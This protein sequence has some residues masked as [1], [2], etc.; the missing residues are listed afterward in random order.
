MHSNK[1]GIIKSNG[2]YIKAENA[3]EPSP[4]SHQISS[5]IPSHTRIQIPP[6]QEEPDVRYTKVSTTTEPPRNAETLKLTEM[7]SQKFNT[8][9]S[10]AVAFLS[11][12]I[13]G[14][15]FH[16]DLSLKK[17]KR[18]KSEKIVK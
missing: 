16:H 4:T 17:D 9:S 1:N 6:M 14:E 8:K 10:E 15:N 12:P 11:P 3:C 5:S 2:Y 18:T 7:R 13:T